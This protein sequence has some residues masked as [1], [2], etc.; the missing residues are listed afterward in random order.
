MAKAPKGGVQFNR[1]HRTLAAVSISYNSS[2]VVLSS[3]LF[4]SFA[5]PPSFSP[6]LS[7]VLSGALSATRFRYRDNIRCK[8]FVVHFALLSTPSGA[9]GCAV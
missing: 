6:L 9:P 3:D 7:P 2:F 4:L 8:N 1:S 5:R